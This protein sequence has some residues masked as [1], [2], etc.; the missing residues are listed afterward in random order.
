MHID[1][2]TGSDEYETGCPIRWGLLSDM[3][4][5]CYVERVVLCCITS[6]INSLAVLCQHAPNSFR[7]KYSQLRRTGRQ[8]IKTIKTG[9]RLAIWRLTLLEY[10]SLEIVPHHC[11]RPWYHTRRQ[12]LPTIAPAAPPTSQSR[13]NYLLVI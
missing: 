12:S 3:C 4:R 11:M 6:T 9:E 1:E 10:R 8:S 13:N 2:V 7:G 5:E